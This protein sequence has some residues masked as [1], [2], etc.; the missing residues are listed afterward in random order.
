MS[1]IYRDECLELGLPEP[2]TGEKQIHYVVRAML[3]GHIM[4]TRKCR[5]IGIY[6]LHSVVSKLTKS[7]LSFR[8]EREVVVCPRTKKVPPYPVDVA[9][10]TSKQIIDYW[11]KKEA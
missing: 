10:M 2:K 7:K 1:M 5:Y 3:S 9:W 4:D 8:L 6:N 11:L